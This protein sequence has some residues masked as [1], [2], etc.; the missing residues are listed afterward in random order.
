MQESKDNTARLLDVHQKSGRLP[1]GDPVVSQ[2]GLSLYGNAEELA[3]AG[4]EG[5]WE[6]ALRAFFSTVQAGD[7]VAMLAYMPTTGEH[8]EL[9][10]DARI[11]IRD[12]LHVA[13]T[14]GY[15]PRFLHSTGQLHKGGPNRGVFIQIT[16]REKKDLDIPGQD[17]SFGTLISA[18]ALGD[19]QSLQK[20]GRRAIRF[21]IEGDHSEGVEHIREAIKQAVSGLGI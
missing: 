7:Y 10:Q 14:F 13:T 4:S 17:F 20:H 5:T 16:A 6:S 8:E 19:L 1:E 15:G 11:G 21:R 9:F 2:A 3:R 18:Q 12:T